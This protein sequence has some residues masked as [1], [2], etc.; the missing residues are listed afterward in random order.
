MSFELIYQLRRLMENLPQKH[1]DHSLHCIPSSFD[2]RDYQYTNLFGMEAQE[3]PGVIDYRATLPPVFDQGQRGT[4]V[5][6]ASIWTVKAYQ[7]IKQGDYPAD[8]LSA[9]FLYALCKQNDGAPDQEGTMPRTAMKILQKDGVCPEEIMPYSSISD[10]PVPQVPEVSGVAWGAA[11]KYK[12]KTYARLCSSGDIKRNNLISSMRKA[13]KDE[14][15]F[16]LALLVCDN[17]NPD[18]NNR[19]PVPAGE[20]RGGHAVGIAGDLPDEGALILRNSWGSGWGDNGYALLPYEWL[21]SKYYGSWSVFEAWTAT[22]L[23]VAKRA[24][25]IEITSGSNYMLVDG[26]RVGFEQTVKTG[27]PDELMMP[28]KTMAEYMGY[29]IEYEGRKAFIKRQN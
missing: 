22:D 29:K 25:M 15:P 8:G 7:E 1:Q 10:L 28:V 13:L 3:Q 12:I 27:K 2:P 18:V 23:P 4:C 17:F 9:A 20:A 11:D 26:H 16:L 5:A 24:N 19:L 14:G 21:D 6:C